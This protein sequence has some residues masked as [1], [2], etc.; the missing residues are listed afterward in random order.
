MKGCG[1]FA[2]S[3]AAVSGLSPEYCHDSE[4]GWRQ[5]AHLFRP[6]D[7]PRDSLFVICSLTS[8]AEGEAP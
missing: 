5:N 3:S 2:T 7:G 4:R 1:S 8:W 6:H